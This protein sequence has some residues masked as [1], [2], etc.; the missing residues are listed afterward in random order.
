MFV[1]ITNRLVKVNTGSTSQYAPRTQNREILT[2]SGPFPSLKIAQ[3]AALTVLGV[4]TCLDAQVWSAAQIVAKIRD[5]SNSHELH[6]VLREAARLLRA[7][8]VE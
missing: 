4:H 8:E 2:V 5:G 3:R 6:A 1:L 7:A